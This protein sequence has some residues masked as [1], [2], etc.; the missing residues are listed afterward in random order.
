MA[1]QDL[2][3]ILQSAKKTSNLKSPSEL[4][5]QSQPSQ[6]DM[7]TQLRSMGKSEAD[8]NQIMSNVGGLPQGMTQEQKQP[9][10]FSQSGAVKP[11]DTIF[12][13]PIGF[14]KEVIA[15]TPG[16]VKSVVDTE[17]YLLGKG[18]ESVR[19][20]A[21]D[22]AEAFTS[23]ETYLSEQNRSVPTPEGENRGLMNRFQ[24]AVLGLGHLGGGAGSIA[25]GIAPV[26]PVTAAAIGMAKPEL[27][28][29]IQ[30]LADGFQMLP[31]EVKE[32]L[33][34]VVEAIKDLPSDVKSGFMDSL[35]STGLLTLPKTAR[36]YQ[37][38][39]D[40]GKQKLGVGSAPETGTKAKLT[41]DNRQKENA[42][43]MRET[44]QARAKEMEQNAEAYAKGTSK[45]APMTEVADRVKEART[46]LEEVKSE[47]GKKLNEL[48]SGMAKA[49]KPID[50]KSIAE[51]MKQDLINKGV[52]FT[53][54]GLDF[55]NSQI[56]DT[57]ASF[58]EGIYRKLNKGG[59][60][61]KNLS[62]LTV[63]WGKE[64]YPAGK[65]PAYTDMATSYERLV[66]QRAQ[67]AIIKQVP[68]MAEPL[69]AYSEAMD[70]WKDLVKALGS[71]NE[72]AT[73]FV[74]LINGANA[75]KYE[76]ILS[77]VDKLLGT[78][79]T[80]EARFAG[81]LEK[82]TG[83]EKPFELTGRLGQ[84]F[85]TSK[86]GI[87]M[88]GAEMIGEKVVGSPLDNIRKIVEY[89]KSSGQPALLKFA[90]FLEKDI[91][92]QLQ[93]MYQG[94]KGA[95]QSVAGNTKGEAVMPGF[96]PADQT[97]GTKGN[98][99]KA[100]FDYKD[101]GG[102]KKFNKIISKFPEEANQ[103]A[104]ESQQY[105]KDS[106]VKYLYRGANP[107]WGSGDIKGTSWTTDLKVAKRFSADNGKIF[108]LKITPEV[109]R[110]VQIAQ[111]APSVS[112]FL[113]GK[114]DPDGNLIK[115]AEVL[116]SPSSF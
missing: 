84:A 21:S 13:N 72:K 89:S 57:D 62:D 82:L 73:Q 22:I 37:S 109:L 66:R 113:K 58:L 63:K 54:K 90:D 26:T 64:L 70:T 107:E 15:R 106:G 65:A 76:P 6:P 44:D 67:E 116:L 40:Y 97:A 59:L 19:Q 10:N 74:R 115:E 71:E 27:S 114:F 80:N 86:R 4:G 11:S 83:M 99:Q 56:P 61:E 31:E 18:A 29:G 60:T 38:A 108:K 35:M 36:Q 46:R 101:S 39:I 51:T 28:T 78:N 42:K 7:I 91:T 87:I 45:K 50:T 52:K 1:L 3:A 98:I 103:I 47:I 69:K 96:N 20:G 68:E 43:I 112:T 104:K 102:Y 94:A 75:D 105:L 48:R 24:Q 2:S 23:D 55:S 34:G 77:K 93:S 33:V 92:P 8:I 81:D 95:V 49:N 32:P 12:T 53:K 14:G 5:I 16:A 25:L 41:L 79:L 100:F 85:P 30:G 111:N 110:R 17:K 88:K 9:L